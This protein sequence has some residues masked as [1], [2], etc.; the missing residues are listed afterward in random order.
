MFKCHRK[1]TSKI[2]LWKT[3]GQMIPNLQRKVKKCGGEEI[4]K[5]IKASRMYQLI[6][7]DRSYLDPDLNKL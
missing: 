7:T 6:A 2:R 5:L 4:Y 3:L 1:E